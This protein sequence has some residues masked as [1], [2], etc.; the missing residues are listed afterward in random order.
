MFSASPS[1]R[2]TAQ[3]RFSTGWRSSRCFTTPVRHTQRPSRN[4]LN[5]GIEIIKSPK[6]PIRACQLSPTSCGK[7]LERVPGPDEQWKDREP[8]CLRRAHEV[9]ERSR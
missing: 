1:G 7:E 3:T 2:N 9:Q 6:L 5:S 4:R 8:R